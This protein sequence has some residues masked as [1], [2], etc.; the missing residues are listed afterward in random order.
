MTDLEGRYKSIIDEKYPK[1][2]NITIQLRAPEEATVDDIVHVLKSVLRAGVILD[3]KEVSQGV[4]KPKS[5]D[6]KY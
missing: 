3:V 1:K 6:G 2:F 5:W 4:V